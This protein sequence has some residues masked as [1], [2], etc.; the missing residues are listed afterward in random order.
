MEE[1]KLK[2]E[3]FVT[4]ITLPKNENEFKITPFAFIASLEDAIMGYSLSEIELHDYSKD[5]LLGIITDFNTGE[6]RYSYRM[7]MIAKRSNEMDY[8]DGLLKEVRD[9]I[10]WFFEGSHVQFNDIVSDYNIRDIE[11]TF[12]GDTVI[13]KLTGEKI[14]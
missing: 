2:N 8:I 3:Q 4:V 11:S 7:D 10:T 14:T 5:N 13:I 9:L 12:Y 6:L 1:T